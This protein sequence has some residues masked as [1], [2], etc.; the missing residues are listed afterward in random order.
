[1]RLLATPTDPTSKVAVTG[2]DG[3]AL[4]PV[5]YSAALTVGRNPLYVA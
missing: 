2:T 3:D 1:M 4:V 5:L